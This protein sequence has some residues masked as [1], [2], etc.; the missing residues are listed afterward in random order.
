MTDDQLRELVHEM[1]S[2]YR[3]NEAPRVPPL[4]VHTHPSH[5]RLP[6]AA[7]DGSCLIEPTVRCVHCGYC[8]SFGH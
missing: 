5:E 4:P 3:Q 7:G 8:Q 1:V 6:L 2:R